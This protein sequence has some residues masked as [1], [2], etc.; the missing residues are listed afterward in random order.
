MS[1]YD[2]VCLWFNKIEFALFIIK[3]LTEKYCDLVS[4][5]EIGKGKQLCNELKLCTQEALTFCKSFLENMD[6]AS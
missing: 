4:E 5:E 3:D 2:E 6:K 1:N